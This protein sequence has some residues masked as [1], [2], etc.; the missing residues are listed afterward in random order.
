MPSIISHHQ[1]AFLG[2]CLISDNVLVAHKLMHYLKNKW[3]GKQCNMVVKLS[4][5]KAYDR[6]EWSYLHK[7]MKNGFS[8]TMD[9]L[10]NGM[11]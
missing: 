9:F 10:D 4:M 2:G 6:V 7:V 3:Y 11:C 5:P 8:L 1:S